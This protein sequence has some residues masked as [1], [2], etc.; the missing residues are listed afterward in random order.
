L[1]AKTLILTVT[2]EEEWWLYDFKGRPPEI[3]KLPFKIPSVWA[4]DNPPV[5]TQNVLPIVVEL[6]LG[7]SPVSQKQYFIPHK[8]LVG[9]QKYFGRLLKY[10]IL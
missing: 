9:I 1:G 5:L 3:P 10:G 8:A 4:E 6:K 7:A 2:Q